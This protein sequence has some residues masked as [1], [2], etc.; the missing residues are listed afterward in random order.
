MEREE[1]CDAD[2]L[3]GHKTSPNHACGGRRLCGVDLRQALETFMLDTSVG[4]GTLV[5]GGVHKESSSL[6]L[7]AN[8]KTTRCLVADVI[9]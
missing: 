9:R 2:L 8:R 3:E 6:H 7:V 1:G 5:Q 4:P